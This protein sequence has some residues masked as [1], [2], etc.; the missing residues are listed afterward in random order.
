[1]RIPMIIAALSVIPA[2]VYPATSAEPKKVQEYYEACLYHFTSSQM[3]SLASR[4][5]KIDMARIFDQAFQVCEREEEG[6]RFA[7]SALS[8]S[9]HQDPVAPRKI[10]IRRDLEMKFANQ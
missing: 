5:E 4:M 6:L 8:A 2:S 3:L 1:M 7:L 9:D 10:Q